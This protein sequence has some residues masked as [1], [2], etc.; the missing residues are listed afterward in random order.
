MN[1]LNDYEIE[2][3]KKKM[4][5]AKAQYL[6]AKE[7]YKQALGP[8]PRKQTERKLCKASFEAL[9]TNQ[10]YYK[11]YQELKTYVAVAK[12]FGVSTTRAA[13]RIA[14]FTRKLEYGDKTIPFY[15]MPLREALEFARGVSV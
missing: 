14:S 9:L 2:E 15:G 13:H 3:F 5:L 1:R 12:H 4:D 8:K 10:E 6:K 7:A 11:K